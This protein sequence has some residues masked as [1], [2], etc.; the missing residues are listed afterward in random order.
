MKKQTN[1][2]KLVTILVGT[3]KYKYDNDV[4]FVGVSGVYDL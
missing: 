4:I 2:A 1:N 3:K